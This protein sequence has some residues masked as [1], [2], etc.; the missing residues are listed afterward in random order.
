MKTS[1][2]NLVPRLLEENPPIQRSVTSKL[3]ISSNTVS[4]IMHENLKFKKMFKTKV[5]LRLRKHIAERKRNCRKLCEKHLK[6]WIKTDGFGGS[7]NG[8]IH[9]VKRN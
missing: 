5:H 6:E 7:I 9:R 3:A 4:R 8:A 1:L 2:G